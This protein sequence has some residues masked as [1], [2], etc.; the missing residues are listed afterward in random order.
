MQVANLP[1]A[2]DHLIGQTVSYMSFQSPKFK[3]K[4]Y[5]GQIGL[6]TPLASSFTVCQMY[7]QTMLYELENDDR[8]EQT[9]V[10]TMSRRL[11]AYTFSGD[12][13]MSG[14]L[15]VVNEN[16]LHHSHLNSN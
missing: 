1:V 11:N 13:P 14:I 16:F 9:N 10:K 3:D 7:F 12:K 6:S 5:L 2:H 15:T 8:F 4:T